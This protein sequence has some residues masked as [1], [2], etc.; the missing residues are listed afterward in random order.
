MMRLMLSCAQSRHSAAE[1]PGAEGCLVSFRLLEL[2][3]SPVARISLALSR[4]FIDLLICRLP[5]TGPA[6]PDFGLASP[7]ARLGC[8][9]TEHSRY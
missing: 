1:R 8:A 6:S 2:R 5:M 3:L 7:R 4:H 9:G